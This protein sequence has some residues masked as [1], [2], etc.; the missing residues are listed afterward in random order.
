M[1]GHEWREVSEVEEL[2]DYELLA[3]LLERAGGDV[4]SLSHTAKESYAKGFTCWA[5]E[6]AALAG[7]AL[8]DLEAALESGL[9][10]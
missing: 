7:F 9:L 8:R 4:A 2:S 5:E 10:G 3:R 6:F 1:E